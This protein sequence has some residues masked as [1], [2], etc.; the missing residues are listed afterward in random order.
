MILIK[1][2]IL[3]FV[4]PRGANL[5]REWIRTLPRIVAARIQARIYAA[6][7]G[8]LGDHK[9]VDDG[10]FELRIHVGA[11]Y[12]VYFGREGR[13]TLV[14]LGG[15]TKGSQARDIARAQKNWK[16]YQG[17]NHGTTRR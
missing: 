15:G 14:L 10:V 12:R 2:Q 7:L 11:G 5:F 8:N 4:S 17:S 13:T 6:E 16:I 1:Y 9:S 3:E